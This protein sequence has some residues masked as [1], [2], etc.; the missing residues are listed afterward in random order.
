[1][2]L[3]LSIAVPDVGTPPVDVDVSAPPGTTAGELAAHLAAE[4]GMANGRLR[5]STGDIADDAPLGFPPLLHGACLSLVSRQHPEP[6]VHPRPTPLEL[7]VVSGPDCGRRFP[8]EPGRHLLGRGAGATLRVEDPGLSRTHGVLS[9]GPDGV[10]IADAGSTNGMHLDGE[11]VPQTGT[12]LAPGQ[13]LRAGHSLIQVRSPGVRPAAAEP[14]GHGYLLVNRAPR[15]PTKAEPVAITLP[16]PPQPRRSARL[17]WLAMLLPLPVCAVLAALMGPQLLLFTL[18]TPVMMLGNAVSDRLSGRREYA[19]QLAEFERASAAVAQS[20]VEVCRHDVAMRRVKFPDPVTVLQTAQGPGSRLWE[21]RRSDPDVLALRVGSG[22]VPA[23]VRI[24][25]PSAGHQGRVP[26]LSEAPVIVDLERLRVLG[27]AGQRRDVAALLRNILGQLTTLH[28]PRDLRLVLIAAEEAVASEWGWVR[29]MPH[30][31]DVTWLDHARCAS[32]IAS[33]QPDGDEALSPHRRP[34]AVE[35]SGADAGRMWSGAR[36]TL[37]II[38]S[39]DL[40]AQPGLAPLLSLS[41]G[42]ENGLRIIAV[43]V[44]RVALPLEC[45]AVLALDTDGVT[46]HLESPNHETPFSFAPDG[47]SDSWAEQLAR[48]MTSLKDSTPEDSTALPEVV[49]LADLHGSAVFDPESIARRWSCSAGSTVAVLGLG[50]GGHFSV[51]LVRDGPHVLV[52]GTTGSGKSQLLQTLV[53]SLALANRPE[54]LGFV[55]VDYK[56]GSAFSTCSNLPH[57]VGMVTDLDG[58]LAQRALRSLRAELSRR[59]RLFAKAGVTDFDDYGAKAGDHDETLGRLVLVIDEF[60]ALAEELPEFLEGMVRLASVGRS[61]GVHL[62]L[63]T[64]RPGGIVSADIRANVNLRIALRF[65]DRVDSEDV[66][67]SP[68]AAELDERHR[69]RALARSGGGR[70]MAFQ[71]AWL[72][73]RDRQEETAAVLRV[74]RHGVPTGAGPGPS[75][76]DDLTG[77]D[78]RQASTDLDRVLAALCSAAASTGSALPRRP[79]HPPLPEAVPLDDLAPSSAPGPEVRVDRQAIGQALSGKVPV[80]VPWGLADDP[81]GQRQPVF[82][83]DA[84]GSADSAGHWVIG[85]AGGSGRTSALRTLGFAASRRHSPEDLHMYAIDGSSNALRALE[86][87]PHAGAIVPR[88]DFARVVRLVNRLAREVTRRQQLLTA[89]GFSSLDEWLASVEEHQG[90]RAGTPAYLLL[91]VDD[92]DLLWRDSEHHDHGQTAERL[93]GLLR[94]GEQ[95]G[96]RAVV[97][98][99]RSVL[100]GRGT[101][102][103]T[104]RLVLRLADPGDAAVVGVPRDS[105]PRHQPP[106]RGVVAGS[107]MEVQLAHLG[108]VPDG[109]AA[110]RAIHDLAAALREPAVN[111][112]F[113]VATMPV[114]VLTTQLTATARGLEFAVGGE[115]CGA[116]GLEFE[117]HGRQVLVTGPARSGKSTA[118]ATLALAARR[119]GHHVVIVAPNGVGGGTDRLAE[120]AFDVVGSDEAARL[121]VLCRDQPDLVVCVDDAD[122]L[123]DT[124][125]EAVLRAFRGTLD[126]TMGAIICAANSVALAS[127]FRGVAVEV[128]RHQTGLLLSPRT[129]A[130]GDL[131]GIRVPRGTASHHPG[132]GFFACHGEAVEV[133]VARPPDLEDPT[134]QTGSALDV[135]ELLAD[136][137]LTESHDIDTADMAR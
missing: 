101:A 71:T 11:P 16:T 98:G 62:V 50:A 124:P 133:Q 100:I 96:V 78:S 111:L 51:D 17:P 34:R 122:Q 38:G 74:R 84:A 4:F 57:T 115:D 137:A 28:S 82:C 132:R 80:G 108:E 89:A 65:R 110:A 14:D 63:A 3:R 105:I 13:I 73:A 113:R 93:A 125:A 107:G 29:L 44:D 43:D 131:L 76:S 2:N 46:A 119:K 90:T 10:H 104:H 129:V 83:W 49:R 72:G 22:S 102:W 118:L 25:D 64:Q 58:H 86:S 121:G 68:D 87:L 95:V 42:S 55:L 21:R 79:W 32:V 136:L 54:D 112:P 33:L 18:M 66:I 12:A 135:G 36:T 123:L 5:T 7:A 77:Q 106:G 56:G 52:G 60:R 31:D 35:S 8:L 70:L 37:I 114:D 61:L 59:E 45:R 117:R 97:T 9:V 88:A 69:G 92:W 41:R 126:R 39:R 23:S 40:R 67:E 85:G 24:I 103:A 109:A 1:M 20:V 30:C 75:P 81:A 19:G 47:C 91:L 116:I 128:S 120:R 130:D 6:R 48:A 127:Q 134:G 94:E 27:I 26:S 15:V 53:V 99:D